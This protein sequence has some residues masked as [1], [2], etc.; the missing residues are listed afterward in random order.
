MPLIKF[1]NAHNYLDTIGVPRLEE[2]TSNVIIDRIDFTEQEND[3]NIE[4]RED[5]VYL[6]IR[7]TFQRGFMYIKRPYLTRYNKNVALISDR[8][9][10]HILKCSTIEQQRSEG[11]FDNRYFWSNSA[12]ISLFDFDTQEEFPNKALNLCYNCQELLNEDISNTEVF[13]NLLD[14]NDNKI[15]TNTEET[16]TD[17]FKRPLNWRNISKAYRE[18]QNYTCEECGFGGNDIENNY[19]KRYLHTHH[20]DS[21]DLLNT[22]R[23]NLKSVCVLCHYNQDEHH[24]S[25][26]EKPRL[27]RELNSFV[28]K[29]REKL[30]EIG[31]EYIDN[32]E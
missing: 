7:G 16:E 25:N 19:D 26:F 14:L 1:D 27:K 3:G 24:Q 5:G 8:P 10:F 31:N 30:I 4:W 11:R 9:R 28:N 17:I 2:Y 21:Y 22:H 13:H 18:E 12:T 32:Y 6:N 23:S 29:Y 20:I 15:E